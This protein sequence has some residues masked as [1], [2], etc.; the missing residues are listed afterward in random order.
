MKVKIKE[1]INLEDLK[2]DRWNG[3]RYNTMLFLQKY[4]NETNETF[5]VKKM[6]AMKNYIITIEGKDWAINPKV[7]EIIEEDKKIEKLTHNFSDYGN[8]YLY[9]E[10]KDKIN[11]I[12]DYLEEKE[13]DR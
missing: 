12:I 11:E 7:F 6:S 13:N 5:E 8:E 9:E 4:Y 10:V 1:N 3:C 2:E